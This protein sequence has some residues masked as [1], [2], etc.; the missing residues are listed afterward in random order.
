MVDF[1]KDPKANEKLWSIILE[2]HEVS[3]D[4]VKTLIAEINLVD[5]E[6]H[7]D[8]PKWDILE[9]CIC[10]YIFDTGSNVLYCS[11]FSVKGDE[12]Y[13]MID[14][15]TGT[16]ET[17]V[18]PNES[19]A[20][21]EN[22][23]LDETCV[24]DES[25]DN[26]LDDDNLDDDNSEP[27]EILESENITAKKSP[28]NTAERKNNK[29]NLGTKQIAKKP[30]NKSDRDISN[31]E[32]ND[33][34]KS[35]YN[36]ESND[37]DESNDESYYDD[38]SSDS[39]DVVGDIKEKP[40]STSILTTKNIK[41]TRVGKNT[42]TRKTPAKPLPKSQ[43]K[44]LPKTPAKTRLDDEIRNIIS[45]V[46][47]SKTT[48]GKNT[49]ADID[50]SVKTTDWEEFKEAAH[51]IYEVVKKNCSKYGTVLIEKI[52]T[53]AQHKYK[54]HGTGLVRPIDVFRVPYH[55]AKM[56]KKFHLP[57]VRMWY[58]GNI[59]FFRQCVSTL[60]SG[61]ND[62]YKWFSCNKTPVDIILKYAQ[63]GITTLINKKER[64]VMQNY[65]KVCDTWEYLT[66]TNV[67]SVSESTNVI[68]YM[69]AFGTARLEHKFFSSHKYN[70]GIREGLKPYIIPDE[71]NEINTIT[72]PMDN[73]QTI[74][75]TQISN[76]TNTSI[77]APNRD[78]IIKF[79][80][81]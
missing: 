63:R 25:D 29:K 69:K 18:D 38:G 44:P 26:N 13:I 30:T 80:D 68:T 41:I 15:E 43:V 75:G 10:K 64:L 16:P 31:D 5:L 21:A 70:A 59:Y 72:V 20:D 55:A 51:V 7:K 27:D 12:T 6:Y 56:V 73:I 39:D 62:H 8:I 24:A 47:R 71:T 3:P 37:S 23:D 9:V 35:C 50:I 33:S 1:Y 66:K 79:R 67:P 58:D 32:S 60:L 14:D 17:T 22:S 34:D 2:P 53:K 76:K 52:E 48:A 81:N 42:F 46:G 77:I 11:T 45:D 4:I 57:C 28:Q 54:I 49:M 19:D 40:R 61:I 36:D 74:D 65:S 78:F